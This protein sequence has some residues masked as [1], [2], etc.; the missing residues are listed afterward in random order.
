MMAGNDRPVIGRNL[1]VATLAFINCLVNITCYWFLM[2]EL[3]ECQPP[4]WPCFC[5]ATKLNFAILKMADY[6]H[7]VVRN[8]HT[9][10]LLYQLDS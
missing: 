9:H 3:F 1:L 10:V 2:I 4:S 8:I 6:C 7:I 5:G